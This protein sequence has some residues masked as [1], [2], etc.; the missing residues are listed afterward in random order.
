MNVY[1]FPSDPPHQA[2]KDYILA[3]FVCAL[4]MVDVAI[5]TGYTL[6]TL[7]EGLRGN[8]EANRT[9]H[10]ENPSDIIGVSMTRLLDCVVAV[11]VL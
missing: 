8:L 9:V 7:I 5:L 6:R 3:L 1:I 11:H 2:I 4:V 10:A